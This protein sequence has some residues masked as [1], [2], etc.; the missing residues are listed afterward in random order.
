MAK[1]ISIRLIVSICI[2]WLFAAGFSV[3][4][5]AAEGFQESFDR[6]NQL[7]EEGKYGEALGVYLET[8]EKG[9]HWKLFYNTGNCYFKTGQTVRAKIYYLKAQR[10]NPFEASIQKNI[11]IVNK[12][13][14]DKIP[15]PRPDF[16]SRV[17]L[18]IES[19]ISLN[20]LSVLLVIII[21][22]FNVFAF[23]WIKKGKSRL[24]IYGVSFSLV[25]VLVVGG[26]HM[27]RVGKHNRRNIAV[28]TSEN[29]QLRSG[30]G[31][32]NTVLF[33]VNPGLKVK[34]IDQSRNWLQVS[35]SSDIAGWLEAGNLERI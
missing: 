34:I 21:V 17:M 19:I 26:Y 1:R 18:R 24:I 15:Y 4:G 12:R 8:G 32:N 16:V 25:L 20:V 23:M 11:D 3:T 31:Q 7:Y 33:K 29:S 22:I 6:A 5:A 10:L 14:N 13:L 2:C 28:I 35:A 9:A 27:Y 30:P